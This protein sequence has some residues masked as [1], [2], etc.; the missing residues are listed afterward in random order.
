MS[1]TTATFD[2][3]MDWLHCMTEDWVTHP[4]SETMAE[5]VQDSLEA[6]E[7]DQLKLDPEVTEAALRE[8]MSTVLVEYLTEEQAAHLEKLLS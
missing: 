7:L 4:G 3:T 1:N 6:A 8:F 2:Q 5:L